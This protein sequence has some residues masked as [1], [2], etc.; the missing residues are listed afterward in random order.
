MFLSGRIAEIEGVASLQPPRSLRY[1]ILSALGGL[2]CQV[3]PDRIGGTSPEDS[4]ISRNLV[5]AFL[6]CDQD[7]TLAINIVT[8]VSRI[9]LN[10]TDT[11][12][13]QT[14]CP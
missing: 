5:V 11:R 12:L 10:Q 1:K 3:G 8:K 7:H 9:R 13:I 14:I 2:R 6:F 4:E